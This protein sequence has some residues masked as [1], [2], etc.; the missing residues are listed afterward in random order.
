MISAY[1]IDIN[2]VIDV[3]SVSVKRGVKRKYTYAFGIV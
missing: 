3:T 1:I 2:N